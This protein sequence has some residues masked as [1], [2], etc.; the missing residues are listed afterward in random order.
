MNEIFFLRII[1][2]DYFFKV[3]KIKSVK[4]SL[5]KLYERKIILKKKF[6]YFY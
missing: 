3:K 2:N 5:K 6:C 4:L 1:F